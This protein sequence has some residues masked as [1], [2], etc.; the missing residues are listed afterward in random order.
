MSS[1]FFCLELYLTKKQKIVHFF[2]PLHFNF[3]HCEYI[4]IIRLESRF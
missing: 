4:Q 3:K 2:V 1:I